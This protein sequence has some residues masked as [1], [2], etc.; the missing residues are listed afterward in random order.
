MQD[1]AKFH[2]SEHTEARLDANDVYRLLWTAKFR[3]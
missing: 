1:G 3:I 2:K